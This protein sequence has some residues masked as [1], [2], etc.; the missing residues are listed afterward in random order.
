VLDCAALEAIAWLLAYCGRERTKRDME[1][2]NLAR[3]VI[4]D[5]THENRVATVK[6]MP[7]PLRNREFVA[8]EICAQDDATG[9]L[10]FCAQSIPDKIDYGRQFKVV[11]GTDCTVTRILALSPTQCK[12][13]CFMHIDPGGKVPVS[14]VNA[15][16]PVA[17]GALNDL[18]VKFCRDV[19][20]D[21]LALRELS[22][23]IE[24][25]GGEGG[26]EERIL[27]FVR[28]KLGALPKEEGFREL[29][30]PDF[31]VKM[32]VQHVPWESGG[33]MRSETVVDASVADVAGRDDATASLNLLSHPLPR[34]VGDIQDEQGESEGARRVRGPGAVAHEDQRPAQHLQCRLRPGH[35]QVQA[36]G[37]VDGC[38]LA[39]G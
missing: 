4:A 28:D 34:S 7:F 36:K 25:G 38:G 33:Y 5:G 3:V 16:L 29:T 12:A 1:Q 39:V 19:E 26:E 18:R 17:L 32:F 24:G 23:V 31:H 20:V 9:D 21:T 37:M 14:V 8:A 13:V 27:G 15:T 11:R 2:G 30:S 10:L 6:K 22:A 35:P